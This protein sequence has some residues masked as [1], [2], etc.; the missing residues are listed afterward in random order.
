MRSLQNRAYNRKLCSTTTIHRLHTTRH[1]LQ[2]KIR[3][4]FTQGHNKTYNLITTPCRCQCHHPR[5]RWILPCLE[6]HRR[7]RVRPMKKDAWRHKWMSKRDVW[8]LLILR[9]E[10]LK[11]GT[12][13]LASVEKKK[14]V[15]AVASMSSTEA[16]LT[17]G[18]ALQLEVSTVATARRWGR[19][20][21]T[22]TWMAGWRQ[23]RPV[24]SWRWWRPV[25]SW[26]RWWQPHR[27]P[28][29]LHHECWACM[30][31]L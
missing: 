27:R 14:V 6:P 28:S 19:S 4:V 9:M 7:S 15:V 11:V 16:F 2:T 21:K 1:N 22:L 12:N 25:S 20:A 31:T 30:R 24:S 5:L 17:A 18:L 3:I 29:P 23:W 10:Q 26:R 8:Y 13:D